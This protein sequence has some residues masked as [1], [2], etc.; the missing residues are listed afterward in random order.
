[1]EQ[2]PHKSAQILA[3]LSKRT[4]FELR[5]FFC[6]FLSK[7]KQCCGSQFRLSCAQNSIFAETKLLLLLAKSNK[8]RNSSNPLQCCF[9]V[10]LPKCVT[11]QPSNECGVRVSLAVRSSLFVE[12]TRLINRAK[13]RQL[14]QI[15]FFCANF[16]FSSL[17]VCVSFFAQSK[18]SCKEANEKSFNVRFSR[19]TFASVEN[20]NYSRI[21]IAIFESKA[22][23]FSVCLFKAFLRASN[24]KVPQV[25]NSC[26]RQTKAQQIC[27]LCF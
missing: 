12:Q 21:E 14:K 9:V 23:L 26:K 10:F 11:L 1:M 25:T 2:F 18:L 19:T 27:K 7:S 24:A 4:S 16:D 15:R 22:K 13:F 6:L 3:E 17:A 20:A 8:F 5:H